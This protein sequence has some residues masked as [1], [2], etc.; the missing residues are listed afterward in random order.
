MHYTN[1]VGAGWEAEKA[2]V[3]C[4][5]FRAST[6]GGM[7]AHFGRCNMCVR[8]R[9]IIPLTSTDRTTILFMRPI[10]DDAAGTAE[11]RWGHKGHVKVKYR[12]FYGN[13][14]DLSQPSPSGKKV[15]AVC[16][17]EV[18]VGESGRGSNNCA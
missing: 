6:G 12:K 1:L 4:Y 16:N 2:Q 14:H 17:G 15:L 13:T 11:G 8:G 10:Y 5:Y 3:I 18:V 7:S 9:G